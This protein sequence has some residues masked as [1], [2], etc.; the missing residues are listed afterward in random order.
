LVDSRL[1]RG[2]GSDAGLVRAA[3]GVQ[4]GALGGVLVARHGG[5]GADQCTVIG[6]AWRCCTG[7]WAR[8]PGRGRVQGT[9]LAQ[10][11]EQGREERCEERLGK[12]ER[13]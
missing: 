13:R 2:L 10:G 4:G 11:R 12:R 1:G 6:P 8:L 3:V 5:L 9:C 7:S